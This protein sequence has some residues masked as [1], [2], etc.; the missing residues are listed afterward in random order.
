MK[1]ILFILFTAT[2][3]LGQKY[4]SEDSVFFDF[5]KPGVIKMDDKEYK[6]S[7]D[8]FN[9]Y[10][11]GKRILDVNVL[12]FDDYYKELTILTG[13][14]IA[15]FS[16]YMLSQS[17]SGFQPLDF[18]EIPRQGVKKI[19]FVEDDYVWVLRNPVYNPEYGGKITGYLLTQFMSQRIEKR[20]GTI[21]ERVISKHDPVFITESA[22]DFG[23]S[24]DGRKIFI[25][26][27]DHY[28]WVELKTPRSGKS[29]IGKDINTDDYDR[30]EYFYQLIESTP[31]DQEQ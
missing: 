2:L 15:Y 9:K 24:A 22:H 3:V 20:F 29:L 4:V 18:I 13:S 16:V 11:K 26:F 7:K 31:P 14:T 19:A 30:R 25:R 27:N 12:T 6:A 5:S 23:K 8:I 28:R 1:I 21:V 10:I 17:G